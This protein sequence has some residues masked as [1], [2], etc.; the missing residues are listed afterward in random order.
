MYSESIKN[1]E[2]FWSAQARE[3]LDWFDRGEKVLEYDFQNIGKVKKP[4]VKFFSDWKLNVSYNCID[5]HINTWKRNKAAI[6]WQGEKES[7]K[8]TYTYQQLHTEVCKFANVLKKHGIKKGMVVTIFLPMIPQLVVAMLACARIGAIHSVVFSAFSA[9]AL[10]DR[11]LDCDSKM[12][13]TSDI[14]YHGGRIID[15][16]SKTDQALHECGGVEKVIVFNRG[17]SKVDMKPGR[18]LWWREE[19]DSADITDN[20]ICEKMDAEDP[21]FV[22]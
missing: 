11:I 7:E 5:R 8:Q 4:Y 3:N 19:V 10:K 21:L 18:D 9:N 17:D 15:L 1:P 14:G 22:L 16:K 13:I 12:V 6:I 2:K 20:C